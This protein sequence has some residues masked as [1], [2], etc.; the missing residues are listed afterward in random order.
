MNWQKCLLK[1]RVQMKLMDANE[2]YVCD[3]AKFMPWVEQSVISAY[4]SS[5]PGIGNSSAKFSTRPR[6]SLIFATISGFCT[7]KA[8]NSFRFPEKLEKLDRYYGLLH[9]NLPAYYYDI[10][11]RSDNLMRLPWY[12]PCMVFW[13]KLSEVHVKGS[14]ALL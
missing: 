1:C 13:V 14:A 12:H 3:W 8:R 4:R 11:D 6:S 2:M 5:S 7:A 10:L 9:N